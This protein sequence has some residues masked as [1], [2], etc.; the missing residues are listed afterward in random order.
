MIFITVGSQKF[1]FNR[2]LKAI[3]QLI[4]EKKIKDN[5]FA[6]IGYSDYIPQNFE[7]ENFLKREEFLEK[8][9]EADIIITH[10]GTGSIINSIK[11]GKLVIAIP[12]LA[13]YK[14][15]VDDH[16]L[17]IVSEFESMGLVMSTNNILNLDKVLMKIR[18]KKSVKYISNTKSILDSIDKFIIE[19]L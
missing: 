11:L 13:K 10:G 17:Q 6:Q 9:N 12:R 4:Y 1:Q 16:Q 19:D 18:K 7:Y 15:H 8:I 3:D 2:I 14:E 5:V